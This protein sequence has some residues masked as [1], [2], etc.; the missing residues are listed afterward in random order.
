MEEKLLMEEKQVIMKAVFDDAISRITSE[1]LMTVRN[2]VI[3][4]A[5]SQYKKTFEQTTLQ[6]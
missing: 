3:E 6:Q 4:Y 5:I 2:K 1:D